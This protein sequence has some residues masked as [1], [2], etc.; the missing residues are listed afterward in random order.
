MQDRQSG[1]LRKHGIRK[2]VLQAQI[3]KQQENPSY[4][5]QQQQQKFYKKPLQQVNRILQRYYAF[6]KIIVDTDQDRY[7]IYFNNAENV[8]LEFQ[9][10]AI[11]NF[12]GVVM[13]LGELVG[14]DINIRKPLFLSLL[15]MLMDM[16]F[17][18]KYISKIYVYY[19][20]AKLVKIMEFM[21]FVSEK[22][23]LVDG[24]GNKSIN[25]FYKLTLPTDRTTLK[26]MIEGFIRGDTITQSI[27]KSIQTCRQCDQRIY[28]RTRIN[29]TKVKKP[30]RILRSL[31]N[32]SG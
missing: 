14:E 11:K 15:Y 23:Q 19:E 24:G 6:V 10:F 8:K 3:Q 28:N 13:Y 22:V 18:E 27:Q 2:N 25:T 20:D 30:A 29:F 12:V 5:Q 9:I 4:L 21:G 32:F 1:L 17:D 26:E 31:F 16:K 7:R